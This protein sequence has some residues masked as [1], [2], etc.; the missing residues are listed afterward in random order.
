M[1]VLKRSFA[2]A[3]SRFQNQTRGSL[4]IEALII[5]LP[6]TLWYAASYA[7]FD[8][9]RIR[10]ATERSAYTIADMISRQTDPLTTGYIDGLNNVY[11]YLV[12]NG[13]FGLAPLP[14]QIRVTSVQYLAAT[15]EYVAVW[16]Y[17]TRGLNALTSAD[18]DSIRNMIPVMP[19]QDTTIILEARMLYTPVVLGTGL[20]Q[21]TMAS[22][23]PTPPR[24][25]PEILYDNG[26][27][28]GP[29]GISNCGCNNTNTGSGT[30]NDQTTNVP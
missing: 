2:R 4:A 5:L 26:S 22:L 28:S 30:G 12:S 7:F 11:D 17:G 20:T 13:R 23:I 21:R 6:L 15:D 1:N 8:I 29:I 19:D 18:V 24:F 25:V 27:G 3:L 14:T 9:Y 16:S 10:I